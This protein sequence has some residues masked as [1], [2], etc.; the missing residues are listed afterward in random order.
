M[1]DMYDYEGNCPKCGTFVLLS[2]VDDQDECPYCGQW[3]VW[4][5]DGV[6][7]WLSTVE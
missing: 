3:G 4:D 6:W 2:A 5:A 1:P 7:E